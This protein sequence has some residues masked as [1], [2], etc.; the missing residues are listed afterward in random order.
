MRGSTGPENPCGAVAANIGSR[1]FG[2][3]SISSTPAGPS[4]APTPSSNVPSVPVHETL[5]GAAA[6]LTSQGLELCPH[7]FREMKHCNE[8]FEFA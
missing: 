8:R 4:S 1:S 5:H 3:D 7:C 2:V 6:A